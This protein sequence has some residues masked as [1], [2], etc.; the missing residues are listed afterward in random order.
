[1]DI[2]FD[3]LKEDAQQRLL[4]EAGVDSPEEKGWD[5]EPVAIIDLDEVEEEDDAPED[6]LEELTEQYDLDDDD[7]AY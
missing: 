1:M 7:Q 5:T 4:E 3:D 6:F 2:M